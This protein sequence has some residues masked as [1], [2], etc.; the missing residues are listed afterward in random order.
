MI[1]DDS[2]STKN[3]FSHVGAPSGNKWAIV[4]LGDFVAL[5]EINISHIGNPMLRVN[6]KWL[7]V[8]NVYGNNPIKLADIII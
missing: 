6:S 5:D 7:V 2:I 8:L 3:G 4:I 1:E